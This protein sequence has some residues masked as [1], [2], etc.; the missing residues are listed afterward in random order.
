MSAET[1][2]DWIPSVSDDVFSKMTIRAVL[3]SNYYGDAPRVKVYAAVVESPKFVSKIIKVL[4]ELAP[5]PGLQ[6]LKRARRTDAGMQVILDVVDEEEEVKEPPAK[7]T[8][9]EHPCLVKLRKKGFLPEECGVV[10]VVVLEVPGV[11][12]KTR[13]QFEKSTTLWPVNFHP[14]KKL[15]RLMSE[16]IFTEAEQDHHIT[17]MKFVMKEAATRRKNTALI[18]DFASKQKIAEG[19]DRRD[20]HPLQHA[21]MVAVDVVASLH[22]GGAWGLPFLDLSFGNDP[23]RRDREIGLDPEEAEIGPYLC[24][25]YDL[26]VLREPCVMCAMSLVHSRVKRVFFHLRNP[27]RGALVSKCQI[28]TIKDLNHH[29][30]VF[31]MKL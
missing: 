17:N 23:V 11:G 25:G 18:V 26:Y 7:R 21:V 22:G 15:E 9:S 8:K 16:T 4:S 10:D 29:Y 30:D 27:D 13:A 5:V 2:S 6:H 24:T 31:E 1:E 28:H 12:P 19:Y 3:N 14:E 20:L